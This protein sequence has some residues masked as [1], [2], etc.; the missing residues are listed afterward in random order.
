MKGSSGGSFV[1]VA[2][3]LAAIDLFGSVR[4]CAGQ[5]I[6]RPAA[7]EEFDGKSWSGLV[8][9]ESRT[10]DIKRAF[11]TSKGAIRPEAMLLPQPEGSPVR[12]DVLM[13]GRGGMSVL[14]GFRIAYLDSPPTVSDLTARL[15]REPE[16]LY[17]RVRYD[18]WSIAAFPDRGIVAFVEGDGPAGQVDVILLCSPS[19]VRNVL[20]GC[21]S[22]P[23]RIANVKE[24]FPEERRILRLGKIR[25]DISSVKGLTIS[26]KGDVEHDLE[27]RIA[28]FRTPRQIEID[29][30]ASGILSV[31][32]TVKNK[33]KKAVVE[34]KAQ[35]SGR[36]VLGSVSV[37]ADSSDTIRGEENPTWRGSRNLENT[38]FDAVDSV[39]RRAADKVD[40]Q[41]PPTPAE[42]RLANWLERINLGTP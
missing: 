18:D 30:A 1:V 25:V 38:V 39:Y 33:D 14:Q 6:F 13:H 12:I 27:K 41:R 32:V 20:V 11:K 8:I 15:K 5:E 23:T 19:H 2:A 10:D 26:D 35:I 31:D 21:A 9:G 36:T 17:S 34:A 16:I 42:L 7:V 24:T 28:R 29:D 3:M 40:A 37:S 22:R 4:P